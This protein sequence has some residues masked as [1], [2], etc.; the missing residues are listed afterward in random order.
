[1]AKTKE[2]LGYTARLWNGET[3]ADS[4]GRFLVD[5]LAIS[6]ITLTAV[7]T[8]APKNETI[9]LVSMLETFKNLGLMFTRA[10]ANS[11]QRNIVVNW[12]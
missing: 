9:A 4:V 7:V 2:I 8:D 6:A 12:R 3:A 11:P 10:N 1:M 5:A